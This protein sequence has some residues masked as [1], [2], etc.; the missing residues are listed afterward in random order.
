MAWPVWGIPRQQRRTAVGEVAGR[1]S[2]FVGWE[3]KEGEMMIN[4][5]EITNL[6][7]DTKRKM[8]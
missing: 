8:W 4:E 7:I 3:M 5:T 6:M 2:G 1:Q